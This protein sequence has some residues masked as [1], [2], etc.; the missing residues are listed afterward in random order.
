MKSSLS[1]AGVLGYDPPP[2]FPNSHLSRLG[3]GVE[4]LASSPRVSNLGNSPIPGGC[5][6]GLIVFLAGERWWRFV[7]NVDWGR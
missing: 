1:A 4:G 7:T 3:T 2:M 5:W 6:S